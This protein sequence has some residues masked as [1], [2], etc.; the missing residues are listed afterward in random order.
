MSALD[1][2]KKRLNPK[3]MSR[4]AS[5]TNRVLSKTIFFEKNMIT[6][7]GKRKEKLSI[8]DKSSSILLE[9][10][11]NI[12]KLLYNKKFGAINAYSSQ[13]RHNTSSTSTFLFITVT[14]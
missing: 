8:C 11:P 12:E 10:T 6:R 1:S 2:S 9:F 14:F 4:Y 7:T 3:K 13:I 5:N